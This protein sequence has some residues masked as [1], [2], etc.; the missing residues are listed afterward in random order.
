L[1][2]SEIQLLRYFQRQ[3]PLLRADIFIDALFPSE[4][5]SALDGGVR[6]EYD[7]LFIHY[8]RIVECS[9]RFFVDVACEIKEMEF[10]WECIAGFDIRELGK[11]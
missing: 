2:F 6:N 10:R 8:D 7:F 4:E 1:E 5:I 11:L 3:C 9:L